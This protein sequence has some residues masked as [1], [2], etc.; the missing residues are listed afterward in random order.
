MLTMK[1]LFFLVVLFSGVASTLVAAPASAQTTIYKAPAVGPAMAPQRIALTYR[2]TFANAQP[3]SGEVTVTVPFP[4]DEAAQTVERYGFSS[5]M[6]PEKLLSIAL[7][8]DPTYG[9]RSL[10]I[11]ALDPAPGDSL[12]FDYVITRR[13]I[14]NP[15]DV[16]VSTTALIAP[17][18]KRFLPASAEVEPLLA[19]KAAEIVKAGFSRDEAI[20]SLY[21]Y[22]VAT[23][24]SDEKEG[25]RDKR[26]PSWAP[27]R[28]DSSEVNGLF[29][30]LAQAAGI[31]AR[32]EFGVLL[33]KV[34]DEP[35]IS[36]AYAW[37]S[38]YHPQR[39]WVPVDAYAG[40][41][42]KRSAE[43]F[44]GRVG[45]DRILFAVGRSADE[46]F[47]DNSTVEPLARFTAKESELVPL[48][49]ELSFKRLPIVDREFPAN[50]HSDAG[51]R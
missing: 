14:S 47:V 24:E 50:N 48:K 46:N 2:V 16:P 33:P 15:L 7:K 4:Q 45:S 23:A 35:I 28:G 29:V 3:V 36:S 9:N 31:P 39:G 5:E 21:R 20:E 34:A 40:A 1:R 17:P 22:A 6:T 25:E 32:L 8:R 11:K 51:V 37:A 13:Q 26:L 44:L 30:G 12:T 43:Y 10:V 42:N 19:R 41:R 38:A 49:L 27:Q 18:D